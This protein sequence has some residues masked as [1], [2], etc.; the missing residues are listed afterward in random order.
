MDKEYQVYIEEISDLLSA[1]VDLEEWSKLC[2]NISPYG[3]RTEQTL[4][5]LILK[6]MS[7]P[8]RGLQLPNMSD[9]DAARLRDT[10]AVDIVAR[11]MEKLKRRM[12]Q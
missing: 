2:P 3:L 10:I 11:T 7:G 12:S 6:E 8:E 4:D 9:R 1:G 5:E